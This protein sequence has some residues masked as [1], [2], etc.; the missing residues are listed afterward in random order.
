MSGGVDVFAAQIV[1]CTICSAERR[2][3]AEV[4]A[5]AEAER[6]QSL[7]FKPTIN[8]ISEQLAAASKARRRTASATG[9][10]KGLDGSAPASSNAPQTTMSAA[11]NAPSASPVSAAGTGATA[12]AALYADAM[13][14]VARVAATARAPAPGCTFAPDIGA[15]AARPRPEA[16]ADEFFG[17]LWREGAAARV[18]VRAQ[19]RRLEAE[20]AEAAAR[21]GAGVVA[22]PDDA[23]HAGLRLYEEAMT[24]L[25]GKR[26]AEAKADAA[27]AA[28]AARRHSTKQVRVYVR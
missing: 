3:R 11:D 19:R 16:S 2:R 12:H 26:A 18:Q 14:R 20:A 22:P 13:A 25:A 4:A 23:G 5:K 21:V 7:V 28:A 17:R 10:A 27:A 6:L 9:R 8:P 24:S 1:M 15:A